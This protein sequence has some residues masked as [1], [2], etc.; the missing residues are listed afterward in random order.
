MYIELFFC[1]I[2]YYYYN[3]H[4]LYLAKP[5][6]K[7]KKGREVLLHQSSFLASS[8]NNGFS[9]FTMLAVSPTCFLVLTSR[10]RNRDRIAAS[11][12]VNP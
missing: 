12:I 7:T 2:Y 3:T 8:S 1:S 9:S 4:T 11:L 6:P 10:V 5:P